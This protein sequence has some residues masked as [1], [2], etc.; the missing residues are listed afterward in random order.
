MV[1]RTFLRSLAALALAPVLAKKQP[2]WDEERRR[3][4]KMIANSN[5]W[6]MP[7]GDSLING[8]VIFESHTNDIRMFPDGTWQQTLS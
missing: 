6:K 1:R 2:D 3:V 7:M 4:N 5:T 8:V